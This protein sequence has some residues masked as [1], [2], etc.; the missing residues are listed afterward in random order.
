MRGSSVRAAMAQPDIPVLGSRNKRVKSPRGL[1]FQMEASLK[2]RKPYFSNP[3]R[4]QLTN[5]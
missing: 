5:P 1:S 2:H 4:N 3:A